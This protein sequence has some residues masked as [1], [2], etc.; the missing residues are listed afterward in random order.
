MSLRRKV[1]LVIAAFMI[2]VSN[3]ILEEERMANDL[4]STIEHVEEQDV[5]TLLK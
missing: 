1:F 5:N 3:V 2:G 4:K